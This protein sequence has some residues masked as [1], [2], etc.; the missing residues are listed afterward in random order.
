V[1]QDGKITS[2]GEV[3]FNRRF[4]Q[5]RW[6]KDIFLMVVFMVILWWFLWCL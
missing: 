1:D 4:Q 6:G 5:S 2:L 3:E